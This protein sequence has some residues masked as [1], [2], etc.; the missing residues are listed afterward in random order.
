MNTIRTTLIVVA[1]ALLGAACGTA[2]AS[3]PPEIQYGRDICVECN[4]IISEARFATAYRLA[5]GTDRKFDDVGDMVVYLQETGETP[6]DSWV[7]DF[8]TEEWIEASAAHFVPTL[9]VSSPMGHSIVA[10]SDLERATAF[11]VDVGGEVIHW[12][13]VRALPAA[14][15]LVGHHH[16]G[17]QMDDESNDDHSRHDS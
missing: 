16:M 4:M 12:D 5:D 3:G 2:D 7:H 9:S 1:I 15:G 11:A 6:T 8:E 13:V 17:I 14:D 10:F